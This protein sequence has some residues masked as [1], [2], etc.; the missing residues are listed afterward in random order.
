M[1]DLSSYWFGLSWM[2]F[3]VMSSLWSNTGRRTHQWQTLRRVISEE[4]FSARPAWNEEQTLCG[5]NKRV[6]WWLTFWQMLEEIPCSGE[7]DSKKRW[8][9][10]IKGLRTQSGP[11]LPLHGAIPCCEEWI[12]S[13]TGTLVFAQLAL[14]LLGRCPSCCWL[15][16]FS[17]IWNRQLI[18]EKKKKGRSQWN[19]QIEWHTVLLIS[20]PSLGSKWDRIEQTERLCK[21]HIVNYKQLLIGQCWL[22]LCWPTFNHRVTAL[23]Q[24]D[25]KQS[26]E[27]TIELLLPLIDGIGCI[28]HRM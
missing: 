7:S 11:L 28:C 10:G 22:W 16:V 13:K 2:F 8:V 9:A 14:L 3:I 19:W 18:Y 27:G 5:L 23:G 15:C 1:A 21:G 4:F 24:R 6:G 12:G 25:V 20:C 17:F 26:A